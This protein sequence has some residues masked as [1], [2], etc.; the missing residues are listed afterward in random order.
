M[1]VLNHIL[2]NKILIDFIT[3]VSQDYL[4]SFASKFEANE[5]QYYKLKLHIVALDLLTSSFKN[6]REGV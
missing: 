4:T 5:A 2:K 3:P 1:K 6:Y